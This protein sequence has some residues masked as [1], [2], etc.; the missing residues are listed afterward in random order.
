MTNSNILLKVQEG[1][2]S[3]SIELRKPTTTYFNQ[4]LNLKCAP[5]L[6]LDELYPNAKEITESMAA[7]S[8]VKKLFPSELYNFG[9][10]DITLIS[11]GDGRSPRTAGLFAYR[12]NWKCISIDP[13]LSRGIKERWKSIKRLGILP[14]KVEEVNFKALIKPSSRVIVVAVH[15]HADLDYT[16]RSVEA[17]GGYVEGVVAIPCCFSQDIKPLVETPT[18]TVRDF[19]MIDEYEDLGIWSD[20]RTIKIWKASMNNLKA[21]G[22]HE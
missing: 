22:V 12:S 3:Y 17:A 8:A 1:D 18:Y 19:N 4:F 5:D 21:E 20:K 2:K 10:E 6:I 11:V 9:K 7:Y 14:V 16:V 15:S 13:A